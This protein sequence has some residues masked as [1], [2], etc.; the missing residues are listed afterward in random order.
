MA[1][2]ASVCSQ[3][4]AILV[5]IASSIIGATE[6]RE[7]S[8]NS[9][10]VG[11]LKC[12][13]WHVIDKSKR[14]C[15]DKCCSTKFHTGITRCYSSSI[16]VANGFCLTWNDATDEQEVGH[17][18]FHHRRNYHDDVFTCC[19]N[20]SVSTF[21]S[22]PDLNNF[23]CGAYNRYG[24]RCSKCIEGYGPAAFSDDITC[25][26]CSRHKHLWVLVLLFQLAMVTLMYLFVVCFG[27]KGTASPLSLFITYSQL[28]VNTVV[29]GSK[30][31]VH[32]VCFASPKLAT[33]LMTLLGVW[34]LDFFRYL[35]PPICVSPSTKTID[36]YLLDY[37]VAI[38]PLLLT[39]LVFL[40]IEL[41]DRKYRLIVCLSSPIV[42]IASLRRGRWSPRETILNTCITFLLLSYS[43]L[44]VVSVYLLIPT[45]S[46]N[47]NGDMITNST[48]LLFDPSIRFLHPE[49]IP[50]M[51]L[52]MFVIAVF[53][54]LPPLALLLYPTRL[55]RCVLTMMRFKRW[56]VLHMVM[57]VFQG[58]YKDGT[59][60]SLDY[61]PLSALYMLLRIALTCGL[62]AVLFDR[63]H[64][65]WI[66]LGFFHICLGTVFFVLKPYKKKWMSHADGLLFF[67]MGALT[68][69]YCLEE[70]VFYI[71]SVT[72]SAFLIAYICVGS[73]YPFV[74]K[75]N[76]YN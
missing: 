76:P 75:I 67:A 47:C 41:Y 74:V 62:A 1:P 38:Y 49:H 9:G 8:L 58:W 63:I 55:F 26:D 39:T 30:T 29:V 28:I 36:T 15:S 60:N 68:T 10:S 21:L 18:L 51:V 73:I 12:P 56:D 22:G 66:V 37:L 57:D 46:Y 32:L 3:S 71:A 6:A 54:I 59:E 34:N 40:L 25:A 65:V 52:A 35:M 5:V 7:N 16:F 44:L 24:V 45:P 72:L 2:L 33:V 70:R 11:E 27:V 17:C 61:R 43:K 13:L 20:C 69:M 14:E 23:T 31:Y 53:V 4:V 42:K 50:Y 48:A 19:D 64:L